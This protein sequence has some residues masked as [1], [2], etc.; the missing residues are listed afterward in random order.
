[1]VYRVQIGEQG[2]CIYKC[3]NTGAAF[4]AA[5]VFFSLGKSPIPLKIRIWRYGA[6]H[7]FRIDRWLYCQCSDMIAYYYD[8]LP[9]TALRFAKSAV[10]G[11]SRLTV[12]HLYLSDTKDRI[13]SLIKQ[14]PERERAAIMALN[15]GQTYREIAAEYGVSYNRA[16]QYVNK[17]G[18]RIRQWLRKN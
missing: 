13:D 9:D 11:K 15:D 1:M 12:H 5:S 8:N 14:L 4:R 16:Q 10:S 3:K 6:A 17:A 7:S 18:I 2:I